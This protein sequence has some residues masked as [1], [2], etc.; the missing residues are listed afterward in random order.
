MSS[1]WA[2]QTWCRARR[3]LRYSLMRARRARRWSTTP[4]PAPRIQ[5]GSN[6][7]RRKGS[8]RTQRRRVRTGPTPASAPARDL[9][10]PVVHPT[11]C[12]IDIS[13]RYIDGRL[14]RGLA[15]HHMIDL[16]ILGLLHE[17]DLHGYELRKR[18][19]DLAGSGPRSRSAR[20]TPRSTRL[21]AAGAV[22]AV[23]AGELPVEPDAPLPLTGSLAG[24]A[25][26]FSARRS[27]PSEPCVHAPDDP[28]RCT[29]SPSAGKSLLV[30]LLDDPVTDDRAF[31][32]K[33]A[34]CRYLPPAGAS[35]CSSAAGPPSPA[36]WPESRAS[37][38]RSSTASTPTCAPSAS[39]TPRPSSTT[40]P[41]STSSSPTSA[42]RSA[43]Q[44]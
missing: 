13:T 16:A 3:P 36:A 26:A 18:I 35:S 43:R 5:L 7:M 40:S 39:T 14:R 38:R 19:G 31:P 23:E 41:G 4:G 2:S 27:A 11:V 42:L 8:G 21:E 34:F 33:V 12:L 15:S 17:Q 28:G 20:C 22:K 37:R 29:A 32:L 44:P 24:E 9:R 6:A 30:E 25:A 10:S 1:G